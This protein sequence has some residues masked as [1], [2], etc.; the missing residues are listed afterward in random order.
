MPDYGTTAVPATI[1]KINFPTLLNAIAGKT[2]NFTKQSVVEA[3]YVPVLQAQ[4][5]VYEEAQTEA[6]LDA[7]I[8]NDNIGKI[9]QYTGKTGNKYKNQSL[10]MIIED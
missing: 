6:S 10:Y 9:Y 8:V 3:I 2:P 1:T 5:G 7:K 4:N